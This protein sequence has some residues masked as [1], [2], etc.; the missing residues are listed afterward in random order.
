MPK[1]LSSLILPRSIAII[2]A[3]KSPEKVGSIVLK[4]IIDSGFSGKIYPVNPKET[5]IAGLTCYNSIEVLPEV[6]DLGVVAIPSTVTLDAIEQAAQKGIK[7]YVV[8]TAGFKEIGKEGVELE[9]KL[10]QLIT[11]YQINLL[12][13][14]C[15]GFA[16]N[17]LPVNVTFAKSAKTQGNLR[18]VSQSGAIAASLFD[19][20]ESCGLGFDQFITIGNKTD[21]NENDLLSF[22]SQDNTDFKQ[23]GFSHYRPIGLYLESIADGKELIKIAKRLSH[24]TPVFALKPGKSEAA[25]HAM[26]SHTGSIAGADDVLDQAFIESG[27]IRCSE[28]GEFFDLAKALSWENAPTGPNVAVISNAGGPAVLSADT[29]S[30]TSLKFAHFTDATNTKLAENLPRMAS[31]ANPVDVLGDALA[32]RFRQSLETVLLEDDV[33]AVIVILT[34]QLM[35]QIESTAQV[36]GEVSQKFS[37]PILCSFIGGNTILSGD[38]ILDQYK[39][40]SFEFP[41]RAIQTLDKMWRWQNWVTQNKQEESEVQFDKN[42]EAINLLKSFQNLKRTALDSFESEKVMKLSGITTPDSLV[43]NNLS[44]A[45]NFANTHQYPVVLKIISTKH[46]HKTEIGGVIT[47]IQNQEELEKKYNLLLDKINVIKED[48]PSDFKIQIQKDVG[49]G[50]EVILGARMDPDF[51]PVILFGAG[52]KLAE[53]IKD[54][55]LRLAPLTA[56]SAQQMLKSSKVSTLLDGY[57]GQKPYDTQE[58]IEVIKKFSQ[59]VFDNPNIKE[60]EINPL[61]INYDGTWAVDPRIILSE[62]S[63]Q[64]SYNLPV[65]KK[66]IVTAHE[67]L[68]SKFHH[69]VIKTEEEFNFKPGQFVSI[70]VDPQK[71]NSYSIAGQKSPHE[72]ELLVDIGPGGLGSKYFEHLKVGD[73]IIHLS[74]AGIFTP[75][76]DDGS[77]SIVFLA[78]GSGIAPVKSMIESLLA[79]G[80]TRP[81]TLYFGLRLNTDVFLQDYF[82]KLSQTHPNFTFKLCLS[83]PTDDWVGNRGRITQF[84]K[85]DLAGSSVSNSS[86]YICGNKNMIEDSVQLL[87]DIGCPENHIYYEK[88]Y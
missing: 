15:L 63:V 81:I 80:E 51:G 28:L 71:I 42:T 14:N 44:D 88:Y 77:Q 36:I 8:F 21:I 37:Q 87:K 22:W 61:I 57:R 58:L 43:V 84:L 18:I 52:G 82:E 6:P 19:W 67:I 7:N 16:N 59:L 76:L 11:K 40:P 12:G 24:T 54:K 55:N 66:S 32:D 41:E 75:K 27:I 72:F 69:F 3:S 47:N 25:S 70:K 46:L 31:Y 10:K 79:S 48:N 56:M 34:P 62:I 33:N 53:L 20:S 29:I 68:A 45:T 64:P 17:T 5:S 78:T 86:V 30:E 35:T 49:G 85:Q 73:E 39:I 9:N 60:I 74:P 38:K 83:Q 50:V 65:F 1:D 23:T 13:P 2:G 4:N 26:R